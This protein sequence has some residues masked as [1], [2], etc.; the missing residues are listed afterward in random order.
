MIFTSVCA[1]VVLMTLVARERTRSENGACPDYES[2]A[3]ILEPYDGAISQVPTNARDIRYCYFPYSQRF[4]MTFQLD[5][6][7]FIA[8]AEGLGW[9]PGA[10]R[11]NHGDGNA[12]LFG[13]DSGSMP[14]PV[15]FEKGYVL[16][17]YGPGNREVRSIGYDE[18]SH[19]VYLGLSWPLP[20]QMT[21]GFVAGP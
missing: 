21:N 17:S 5:E 4:E 3:H 10:I 11:A 1:I 8:W 2:L 19:T 15:Y 16:N 9:P 13:T 12:L 14:K 18:L 6:D 7:D 20:E